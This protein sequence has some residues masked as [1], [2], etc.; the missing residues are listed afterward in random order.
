MLIKI[1]NV[2][3]WDEEN[4]IKQIKDINKEEEKFHITIE[5]ILEKTTKGNRS[6]FKSFCTPFTKRWRH[7]WTLMVKKNTFSLSIE[8]NNK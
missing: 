2:H 6:S 3:K 7:Y 8:K 1:I 4:F 5:V